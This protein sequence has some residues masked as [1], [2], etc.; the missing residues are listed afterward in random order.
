M[1]ELTA[2]F[3]L[4]NQDGL[5][6]KRPTFC[7]KSTQYPN[8]LTYGLD[9]GRLPARA[10]EVAGLVAAVA[11]KAMKCWDTTGTIDVAVGYSVR[12]R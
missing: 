4:W 6:N 1:A 12:M 11:R 2:A 10:V 8:V 5:I 9:F 7:G 3:V